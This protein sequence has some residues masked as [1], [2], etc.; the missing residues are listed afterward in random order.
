[1]S[2]TPGSTDRQCPPDIGSK[3]LQRLGILRAFTLPGQ[4]YP[5]RPRAT[6]TTRKDRP[7]LENLEKMSCLGSAP[8]S[9]LKCWNG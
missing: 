7:S 2:E 9:N 1:V 4:R 5:G 8:F 3:R 6:A